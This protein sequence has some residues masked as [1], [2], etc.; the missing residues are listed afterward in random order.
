VT[1]FACAALLGAGA[2]P[3]QTPAAS[4]VAS[5]SALKPARWTYVARLMTDG[6]PNRLGFRTLELTS[7]SYAG[8]PAWL[9]VDARKIATV[10]LAESLYV[11]KDDLRPLHRAA[12]A[13]GTDVVTHYTRDSVITTFAGDSGGARRVALANEP[14]LL[15]SLYWVEAVMPVLPLTAGWQATAPTLFVG[16]DDHARV[17]VQLRVVGEEPANIPD[18]R[19]DCWVVSLRVG[20]SEQ[21]LWVRKSDRLVIKSSAPVQGMD[22]A[23]VELLLAEGETRR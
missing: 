13:P 17:D 12:H 3:A 14:N 10:T 1:I 23:A 19:F 8:A 16:P 2:L 9:V 7:S 11:A 4:L 5:G 21:R 15:G 20:Q 22:G 6:P 18:G